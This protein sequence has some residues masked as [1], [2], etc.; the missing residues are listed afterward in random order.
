MTLNSA[1]PDDDL[2][3][4]DGEW[5]V[6][7]NTLEDYPEVKVEY[8]GPQEFRDYMTAGIRD[9]MNRYPN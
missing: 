6:T 4:D 5:I 3:Q 2:E 7:H 9:L 1:Q 8:K